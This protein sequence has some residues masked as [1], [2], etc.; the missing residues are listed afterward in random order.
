M[1]PDTEERA[2][3]ASTDIVTL[4]TV[5]ADRLSPLHAIELGSREL[6]AAEI[7]ASEIG[8]TEVCAAEVGSRQD[9]IR[10]DRTGQ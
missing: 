5:G 2:L 8:A 3:A 7:G 1:A 9:G 10:Q 4:A 6:R